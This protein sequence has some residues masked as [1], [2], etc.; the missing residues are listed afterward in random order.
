MKTYKELTEEII[1]EGHNRYP[2]DDMTTKELKIAVNAAKNILDMLEDGASLQRWQISAIVVASD[3]LASVCT[4][5]RVDHEEEMEYDE[6][7]MEYDEYGYPS[8]YGE[9]VELDEKLKASDDMGT[10]VKD[11]QD[12]DAPQFKG[13]SQK[14]RQKM[15]IA[16]KLAAMRNEQVELDEASASVYKDMP[17][18]PGK[19]VSNRVQV[20]AFK[21]VNAMGAFL[22]KQN[23]NSWQDTGVAGLKSGKYKIDTVIKGGKPSKNFIK[24]N[25][26]FEL[27]EAKIDHFIYQ[28]GVPK[29]QEV[30]HRGTEQSS[31]DWI[32]KNAKFYGHKGKDFVIY[33]G[34]YPNVKP[35][36]AL[37]FKY[38][39]EE[40][41]LDEISDEMKKKYIKAVADKG[42]IFRKPRPA[43]L[44]GIDKKKEKALVKAFKGGSMQQYGKLHDKSEKRAEIATRALKSLKNEEVELAEAETKYVIKHKKTKE[45][46]NTHNDYETAKDEHEGLGANKK[47]YGVYKQTKKD[48]ALRNRSA[49]RE[50]VELDEKTDYKVSV[51]GLPD[52]YVKG[53][54]PSE[55]KA[56]LRKIVKNP[57]S[58]RAIER[59]TPSD[60]K[61]TFRDKAAGKEEMEEAQIDRMK[62]ISRGFSTRPAAERHN[63]SLVGK[64]KASH[65]SYV[66]YHEDGKFY[67]VDLK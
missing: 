12:S 27:D 1:S 11:F 19:M 33:K 34:K 32:E 22:S 26:E 35:S 14:E 36:D 48:A 62:F 13:K 31:K 63:D 6:M 10:W 65:Q 8:M 15:G 67:V 21:D 39:A 17:K 50:E 57:K 3:E 58:I 18:A 43:S 5:M 60:V 29:T 66:H 30:V 4:S 7:E 9:E 64:N 59:L 37:D 44:S 20:K 55:I 49:Y 61:K 40:V 53:K 23:D 42:G 2:G 46:L 24:I 51:D 45:V 54:S 25:E 41:E 52:M 28:K 16:A 38:V 56:G 47:D